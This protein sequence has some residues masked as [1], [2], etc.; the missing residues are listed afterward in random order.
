MRVFPDKP[1]KPTGSPMEI[2][3][4]LNKIKDFTERTNTLRGYL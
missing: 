2:N 4:L 1:R 3:P